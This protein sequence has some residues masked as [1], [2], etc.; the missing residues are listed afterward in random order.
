MSKAVTTFLLLCSAVSLFA[1]SGESSLPPPIVPEQIVYRH[2]PEQFIQWIGPELPY[3]MIELYIDPGAGA[4]PVYDAVLT[5][6]TTGKRIHYANQ[7]QMVDI[8]KR[9]GAEAYLTTVQFDRPANAGKD[10][11]YLLRFVDHAGEP[12]S[13]QFIQGSD[14]SERG[15]GSSPAGIDPPVLMYRER[16][17]VAGEGAAVKI[18][19]KVS[20]ADVWTEI[21]QPPYFVAYHGAVSEN[22]DI[23]VFAG[24][25]QQWTTVSAPKSLSVGAEWKLKAQDGLGCTLHVQALDGDHATIVDSDDH[26]PGRTVTIDGTWNN[27]AWSI[28]KLHYTASGADASKDA[29]QGLTIS[30]APGANATG[31]P[32]KFE[33]T[34]GK[35]TRIA[36]GVVHGD[37][38]QPRVG[39]E[40]KDPQWLRGKTAWVDSAVV[41][42]KPATAQTASK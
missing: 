23:A 42:Q 39:W 20:V 10:A 30:F 16:S 32:S 31:A 21:S 5:E 22:V 13:W 34:A 18:G 3:T 8:D 33:V 38:G 2:W 11:T 1:Q 17:A 29:N 41:S 28:E 15:G 4:T 35:K 7:Q 14:I 24:A 9:S 6:R 27:G 40:F 26:L 37:E 19:N 36:S 25:G 12:V